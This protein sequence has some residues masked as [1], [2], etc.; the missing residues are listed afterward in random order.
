VNAAQQASVSQ[1]QTESKTMKKNV[2]AILTAVTLC[3]C[4]LT[5]TMLAI[6]EPL[7]GTCITK[8]EAMKKYPPPKGGYPV[9]SFGPEGS[10]IV[11]SPYNSG[12]MVDCRNCPAHSLVVDP[13]AK[14]VFQKP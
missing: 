13:F 7:E 4:A 10:G 6:G 12:R 2:F 1:F 5:A 9:A 3:L 14:K 11:P 8:E